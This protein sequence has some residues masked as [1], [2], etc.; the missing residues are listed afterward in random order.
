ME[1]VCGGESGTGTGFSKNTSLFLVSIIPPMLQTH[2]VLNSAVTRRKTRRSVGTRKARFF[3]TSGRRRGGGALDTK[4]L[5]HGSPWYEGH[6]SYKTLQYVTDV[7]CRTNTFTNQN[8]IHILIICVK[9][10]TPS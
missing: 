3:W 4:V 5:P 6:H 2:L 10:V 1:N 8:R 9:I 7:S